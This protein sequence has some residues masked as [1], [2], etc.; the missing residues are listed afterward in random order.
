MLCTGDTV[1]VHDDHGL[2]VTWGAKKLAPS[3]ANPPI[4]ETRSRG[5]TIYMQLGSRTM[6][7]PPGFLYMRST[8]PRIAE[9]YGVNSSRAART[10]VE[11]RTLFTPRSSPTTVLYNKFYYN[12]RVRPITLF[13]LHLLC[14]PT[15]SGSKAVSSP[16]LRRPPSCTSSSYT[17][18]WLLFGTLRTYMAHSI[19]RNKTGT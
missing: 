15:P 1:G 10:Y 19:P 3:R 12:V 16:W 2:L 8:C 5:I 14:F 4:T 6:K 7:S 9:T 17:H 11:T 18:R 13:W